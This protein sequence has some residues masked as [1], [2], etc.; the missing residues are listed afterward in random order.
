MS[1]LRSFLAGGVALGLMTSCNNTQMAGS[2]GTQEG[3]KPEPKETPDT[4]EPGKDKNKNPRPANP[5]DPGKPGSKDPSSQSDQGDVVDPTEDGDNSL[6]GSSADDVSISDLLAGTLQTSSDVASQQINDNEL[7]F[8]GP[9]SFRIGDNAAFNTSCS[10]QVLP[11]LLAG[12]KFYFEFK[13]MKDGANVTLS[14]EE[15]C[16]IDYGDSNF[17]YVARAGTAITPETALGCGE[18]P[19]SVSARGLAKGNYQLVVESRPG[20]LSDC[21]GRPANVTDHDDFIVGRVR[22]RA[23]G[24]PIKPGSVGAVP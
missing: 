15:L 10:Q 23:E 18:Q 19:R 24:A 4:G 6:D 20:A 13:V 7:V 17:I 16:G 14:V 1:L 8:G 22:A 2:A 11:A 21:W 3:K 9:K 5:G 12:R